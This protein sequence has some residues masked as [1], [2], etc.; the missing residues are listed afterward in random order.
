ML[1]HEDIEA[2]RPRIDQD[3]MAVPGFDYYD[4]DRPASQSK[5]QMP[6][7]RPGEVYGHWGHPSLPESAKGFLAAMPVEDMRP[8]FTALI[9]LCHGASLRAGWWHDEN[10]ALPPQVNVPTLL[11]LIVSE[12]SEAME[13][14]RKSLMDDKVTYRPGVEVELADAVIRILDVS[15]ALGLDLVGAVIDKLEY[16]SGR[17]DHTREARKASGGKAY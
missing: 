6:F 12:I 3:S 10:G 16:N 13:A 8:G 17:R 1:T 2:M 4:E 9:D 7:L 5:P 15:G 11:M 14:H